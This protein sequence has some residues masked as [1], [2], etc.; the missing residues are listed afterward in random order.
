MY[1]WEG[2]S[3]RAVDLHQLQVRAAVRV[4]R[5]ACGELYRTITTAI[6]TD[7]SPKGVLLLWSNSIAASALS[8]TASAHCSTSSGGT[9]AR[10]RSR[11]RRSCKIFWQRPEVPRC[12]LVKQPPIAVCEPRLALLP[13]LQPTT[14]LVLGGT[15]KEAKKT[16]FMKMVNLI[17]ERRSL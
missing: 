11:S 8:A 6:V 13:S 10:R 15:Q 14:F 4:R 3:A 5:P 7:G 2:S 12:Y 16:E 17:L 1:V 9:P